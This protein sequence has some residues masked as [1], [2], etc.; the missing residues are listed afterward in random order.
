[1]LKV[2]KVAYLFTGA[3]GRLVDMGLPNLILVGVPNR[4]MIFHQRE[5]LMD[6]SRD[7]HARRFTRPNRI[8]LSAWRVAQP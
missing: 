1:M 6:I 2:R 3:N 7:H 8:H 4:T 5:G